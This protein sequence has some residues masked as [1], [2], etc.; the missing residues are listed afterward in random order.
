MT[1][2]IRR[3]TSMIRRMLGMALGMAVVAY[4]APLAAEV[5][6]RPKP[7]PAGKK[8]RVP[9]FNRRTKQHGHPGGCGPRECA[10]RLRQRKAG[11]L[12]E[13]NGTAYGATWVGYDLG[14]SD[15]TVIVH[16]TTSMGKTEAMAYIGGKTI[17]TD[18]QPA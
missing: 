14:C 15:R 4:R 2:M 13:S 3:M 7:E 1:S 12:T 9:W 10:R 5:R 18:V 17:V 16:K 11:T 8:H 6:V